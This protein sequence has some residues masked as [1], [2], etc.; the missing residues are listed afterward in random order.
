MNFSQPWADTSDQGRCA[1]CP[2]AGKGLTL[3]RDDDYIEAGVKALTKDIP[4]LSGVQMAK[5]YT[6]SKVNES[7]HRFEVAVRKL[8]TNEP[9]TAEDK[10]FVKMF[11]KKGK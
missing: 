2:T 6:M 5:S 1:L 7:S 9:L 4:E 11:L 8:Q 10:P 3:A